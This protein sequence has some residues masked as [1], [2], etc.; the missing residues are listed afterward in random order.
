[1]GPSALMMSGDGLAVL[2]KIAEGN[3]ALATGRYNQNVDERN[4][5]NAER[6]ASA[7]EAQIREQVR[8]HLG[9]QIAAQGEGGFQ[10]G[11]GANL[12]ALQESQV[13]G[14]LDVLNLRR[15]GATAAAAQRMGGTLAR[16]EGQNRARAAYFGA[17]EAG[18]KMA[19]DYASAAGGGG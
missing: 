15:K 7:Q 16:M 14:M 17:A 5:L 10:T 9:G 18:F 19:K 12:D 1:M 4:A 8:Q 11:T 2:G 3:S 6:D 13:N